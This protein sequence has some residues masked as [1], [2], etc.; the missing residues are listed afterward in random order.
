MTLAEFID[1]GGYGAYVWS[2]Y[3]ITAV[4]LLGLLVTSLVRLRANRRVLAR[5]EARRGGARR[6]RGAGRGRQGGA[7]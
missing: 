3:A 1:L 6:A 2:S 7:R 5:L 4:L